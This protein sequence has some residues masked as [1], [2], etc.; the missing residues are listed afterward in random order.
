MEAGVCGK[1]IEG[2]TSGLNLGAERELQ[3][4]RG[5]NEE[6]L[7]EPCLFFLG[8]VRI[9]SCDGRVWQACV[10]VGLLTFVRADLP[11]L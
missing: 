11:C 4:W 6:E 3:S 9:L 10:I 7:F 5:I 8:S 1:H 2:P